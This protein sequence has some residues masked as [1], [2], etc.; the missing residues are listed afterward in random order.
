MKSDRCKA[1]QLLEKA[2]QL[3]DA[4]AQKLLQQF[5]VNSKPAFTKN[6]EPEL[7]KAVDDAKGEVI[8]KATSP[9][10]KPNFTVFQ[11]PV[12]KIRDDTVTTNKDCNSI[13]VDDSLPSDLESSVSSAD[14]HF[15]NFNLFVNT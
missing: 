3:G 5:L 8:V 14:S 12:A 11:L 15:G 1:L 2:T 6:T 7:N 4:N 10:P 9:V 13:S